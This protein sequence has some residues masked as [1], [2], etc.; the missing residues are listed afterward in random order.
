[1]ATFQP[2]DSST[3]MASANHLSTGEKL[4]PGTYHGESNNKCKYNKICD[5]VAQLIMEQSVM[6]GAQS[7]KAYPCDVHRYHRDAG[8]E[9]PHN[10]YRGPPVLGPLRDAN[11]AQEC[12]R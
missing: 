10:I 8:Q 7:H 3:T 12:E 4:T 9:R 2:S 6:P 11:P 1:M 5:H